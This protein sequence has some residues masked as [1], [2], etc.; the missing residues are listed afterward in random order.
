MHRQETKAMC[1]GYT[2]A[3]DPIFMKE[4]NDNAIFK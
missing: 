4:P 2:D 3:T 1:K